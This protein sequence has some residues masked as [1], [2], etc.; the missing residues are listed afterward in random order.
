[1]CSPG[2]NGEGELRGQPANQRFTWKM[3]V[4]T[5]CEWVSVCSYT[6][7][8][9]KAVRIPVLG[10]QTKLIIIN[11]AVGCQYFPS[12]QLPSRRTSPIWPVSNH[13]ASWPRYWR[14]GWMAH[15][16]TAWVHEGTTS[17]V[18]CWNEG[19]NKQRMNNRGIYPK[20]QRQHTWFLPITSA[21]VDRFSKFF[22][23]CNSSVIL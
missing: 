12:G 23:H 6:K 4:K 19:L 8:E 9:Q 10:S 5:E 3:A 2:I 1:M 21:N 7:D 20:S 16:K 17:D 22:H 15:D 18:S 13:T 11:L 14:R